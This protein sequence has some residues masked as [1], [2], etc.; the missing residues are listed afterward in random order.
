MLA[1][2]FFLPLSL[3]YS[4]VPVSLLSSFLTWGLWVSASV[5]PLKTILIVKGAKCNWIERVN[6]CLRRTVFSHS[7]GKKD[8]SLFFLG[9]SYFTWTQGWTACILK[10]YVLHWGF[11][12]FHLH[13]AHYSVLAVWNSLDAKKWGRKEQRTIL[14]E[15]WTAALEPPSPS[16]LTLSHW[17]CLLNTSYPLSFWP[18]YKFSHVWT[19]HV[20]D[21]WCFLARQQESVGSSPRFH[22]LRGC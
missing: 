7:C 22:L 14:W 1:C 9:C 4:L 3:F 10:L 17:C 13:R 18:R 12:L 5:K 2:L 6:A 11:L 19:P 15:S 16:S 8:E 21:P 20:D